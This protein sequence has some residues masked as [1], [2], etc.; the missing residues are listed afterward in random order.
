MKK[1]KIWRSAIYIIIICIVAVF[2][3]Q[4]EMV[5]H[6]VKPV[7]H[8]QQYKKTILLVPLDSRPPCNKFV[9]EAGKLVFLKVITPP[10]DILDY[11]TKPG[12]PAKLAAWVLENSKKADAV[13]ISADQMLYGGLLASRKACGRGAALDGFLSLLYK[14]REQR[15][16]LPIYVFNILPRLTPPADI[17]DPKVIKGLMEY[18]RLADKASQGQK[19]AFSALE[20]TG[21]KLPAHDLT[22]YLNL[23]RQNTKLNEMLIDLAFKGVITKLVIGQD[24]GEKYGIPNI[25]KRHLRAYCQAKGLGNRSVFITHGADEV[26]MTMLFG[27]EQQLLRDNWQPRVFVAYDDAAS[28]EKI[29]PYMAATLEQTVCEKLSLSN[30]RRVFVPQEADFILYIHAGDTANLS[31]RQKGAQRIDAWLKKGYRV[32]VVDLSEHFAPYETLFP[33]LRDRHVPLNQL[34]TYSGWN[35]ASNSIGT[36]VAQASLYCLALRHTN[37]DAERWQ[38]AYDNL[39]ILY[40]HFIED[41]FYLKG[42]IDAINTMLNKAGIN[43]VNDLDM[44]NNYN[45]ANLMLEKELSGDLQEFSYSQSS[46]APLP[47]YMPD[48]RRYLAYVRDL[49]VNAFYPWP[50][51][52]EIYTDVRFNLYA[53]RDLGSNN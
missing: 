11:Y 30:A 17:D 22:E 53:R 19:E 29:M 3:Q 12:K 36:S 41:Y 34:I 23:Y 18:S 13:L 44:D 31:L 33:I 14:L 15:P 16:D 39:T 8:E 7:P 24:D 49:S 25:E 38:L 37:T 43:N 21:E 50:R 10:A 51:T 46:F 28:A 32:A 27:L 52:F 1:K 40:Q 35:T 45:W 42:T 47:V 6:G 2:W 20:K 9:V 26:A 5:L 48:G 4:R